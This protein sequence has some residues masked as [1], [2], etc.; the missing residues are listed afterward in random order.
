MKK[1]AKI[2]YLVSAILSIVC[3]FTFLV[4]G[5]LYIVFSNPT[6][7]EPIVQLIE[8]GKIFTNIPLHGVHRTSARRLLQKSGT[9]PG[10]M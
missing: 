3:A 5:I 7:R 2:I 10:L 1:A 8:E 6:F 9:F 4:G